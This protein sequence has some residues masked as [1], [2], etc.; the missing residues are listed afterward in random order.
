M[1]K[2]LYMN[3][4]LPAS[5]KSTAAKQR[6][7]DIGNG[8]L[9]IVNRD[10]LRTMVDDGKWS[11]AN[12][13]FITGIRDYIIAAAL[14][15]G[16]HVIVD[17]TNLAP[18]VEAH[19]RGLAKKHGADFEVVDFTH[20]PLT[21]CIARDKKRQNYVGESVIRDMHQKYLAKPVEPAKHDPDLPDVIL[22][23]IDGTVAQMNGRGPFEWH[24]VGEDLPRMAVIR[25]VLRHGY[26]IIFLSGRDECCR[27][28]TTEWLQEHIGDNWTL[29]MRPA[30]DQRKDTIVKRE[31]YEAHINGKFNVMAVFDDRHC[32]ARD[33]WKE[34]G[35]GDRLFRVGPVD[36]DD[37]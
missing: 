12:E 25:S 35:L 21:E 30:A 18:K 29:Y 20:V 31:M 14:N 6:L 4:G 16:K 8:N 17:D 10:Q 1:P 36:E 33:V 28:Q 11:P 26:P 24:R 32:V 22:V 23:D 7:H 5:G 9:K 34:V 19:L 13:K 15:S 37:F 2:T 3:R 27:E